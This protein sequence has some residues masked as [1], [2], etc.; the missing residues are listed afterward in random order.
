MN[1]DVAMLSWCDLTGLV[2]CRSVL[3]DQLSAA[4]RYGV[5]WPAAG[6]AIL[7]FGTVADNPWGPLDEV[8]QVPVGTNALLAARDEWPMFNMVLTRSVDR[9]GKPWDC[10]PRSFCDAALSALR[11][12]TGW[13]LLSAFEFEFTRLGEPEVAARP[14]YTLDAFRTSAKFFDAAV[15][16]LREAGLDP[17]T[18]EPEFGAGQLEIACGP[19]AGM[20]GPDRAVMIREV[21]REVARRQDMKITFSP[22]PAPDEVGNGQHVHFSFLDAAGKPVL[23][24]KDSPALIS[25]QAGSFVA[26]IM[27]HMPAICAIAAPAPISYLRLGPHHWSCGYKSFGLQNREAAIRVCPP[28]SREE[29]DRA[30][31]IN[32]EFRPPDGLCNPYLLIGM[33]AYAGLSG[34]RD[35]LPL[36]PMVDRD[37]ADLSDEERRS[38][39][40]EPL[41]ASLL[42]AL[43]ALANDTEARSWMPPLLHDAFQSVKRSEIAAVKDKSPDELCAIYRNIY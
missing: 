39:G 27:R 42:E 1:G 2:R 25:P 5:G 9:D 28:A 43:D 23:Y 24:D 13:T 26:G 20:A 33:L 4:G 29:A 12:E 34:I 14:V 38:L 7:P 41:P 17:Q 36:P 31:A 35:K 3:Q 22:K 37:P 16:A 30:R 8:R 40:I 32:L 6:Q 15:F 18:V 10:C 21:L 11:Q 19:A